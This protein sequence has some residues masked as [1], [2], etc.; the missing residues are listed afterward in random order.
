MLGKNVKVKIKGAI[1]NCYIDPLYEAKVD[2]IFGVQPH[3]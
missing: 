1:V 3:Y 2:N